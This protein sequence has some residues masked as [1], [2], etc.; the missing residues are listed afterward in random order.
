MITKGDL[1]HQESKIAESGLSDYFDRV[2]ILT[3]KSPSTYRRILDDADVSP[4][5]F[6]MVGN[7]LRSDILPVIEAGGRA[8]HV[9][10]G[11]TWGHERVDTSEH[12]VTW[13]E[14]ESIADVPA[15]LQGL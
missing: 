10:Y 11:I 7:S 13:S 14:A 15:L 12:N 9:P 4:V 2:E 1:F 6:V 5:E 8:V 3:E